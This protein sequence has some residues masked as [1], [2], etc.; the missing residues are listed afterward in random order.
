[1]RKEQ[2]LKRVISLIVAVCMSVV[3]LFNFTGCIYVTYKRQY[4]R[5]LIKAIE[6]NDMEKLQALVDKGGDL[7]MLPY[8][9][10]LADGFSRPPLV[11]AVANANFEAVKILVEGGADVNIRSIDAYNSTPLYQAILGYTNKKF[12]QNGQEE[13][14]NTYYEIAYYLIEKGADVNLRD[15]AGDSP[16]FYVVARYNGDEKGFN[17]F[18][19]LLE[20]GAEIDGG[21]DGHILMDACRSDNR[22]KIVKHL[23]ENYEIDVNTRSTKEQDTLLML[24]CRCGAT[25]ICQYLLEQGAD[26]TLKGP[27]GETAY[28]IAVKRYQ[29]AVESGN[30]EKMGA[31]KRIIELLED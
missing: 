10:I 18:L 22:L 8:G 9:K 15:N 27:D 29:L 26:K 2:I 4:S 14:K 11:V 24:T 21:S 6:A 3:V 25:E 20:Q 31:F 28:D 23:F 5:N 19:Y 17:L 13:I 1:M 16:I 7:D 12:E 30:A